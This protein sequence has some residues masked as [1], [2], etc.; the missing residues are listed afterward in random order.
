MG[1]PRFLCKLGIT[2]FSWLISSGPGQE[3]TQI[4]LGDHFAIL[5]QDDMTFGVVDHGVVEGTSHHFDGQLLFVG[6]VPI[7]SGAQCLLQEHQFSLGSDLNL[8]IQALQRLWDL[9]TMHRFVKSVRKF[10]EGV[11]RLLRE[12]PTV[13]G[14]VPLFRGVSHCFA[15]DFPNYKIKSKITITYW[16]Y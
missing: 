1:K 6:L 8:H 9:P 10:F 14:S 11:S 3:H 7:I 2:S 12:C 15:E 4:D 13:S 5:E 16:Y